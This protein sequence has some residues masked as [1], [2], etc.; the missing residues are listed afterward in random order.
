ME[1]EYNPGFAFYKDFYEAIENLPIED[2]MEICYAAVKYGITF[3]TVDVKEMPLGYS[4]TRSW[5]Q[6]IDNSVDRWV[7]NQNKAN[8][9]VDATMSRDMM[10]AKMIYEGKKSKEIAEEIGSITGKP[11]SE[12]TIRR[13]APWVERT[14]ADFAVK[15]LG[16]ACN[17]S[18]NSQKITED[19]Q[20]D[21]CEMCVNVRADE[22]NGTKNSQNCTENSQ[23]VNAFDMF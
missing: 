19:E 18:Q 23:K 16:S 9:K 14:N 7:L 15:W 5:K 21:E 12:S 2:Q 13:S 20:K 11:I 22:Q 17:D 3:E 1:K 4:F 8:F 6:A 10:I